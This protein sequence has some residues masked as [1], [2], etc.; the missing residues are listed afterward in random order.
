MPWLQSFDACHAEDDRVL[1][2]F[3]KRGPAMT[4]ASTREMSYFVLCVQSLVSFSEIPPTR[5]QAPE[6]VP[7]GCG[8]CSAQF[9]GSQRC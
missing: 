1:Q 4:A 8:Q 6:Q 2:R 9:A 5:L 7:V 3:S